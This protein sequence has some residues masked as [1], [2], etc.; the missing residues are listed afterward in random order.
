MLSPRSIDLFN[1]VNKVVT[2]EFN[3]TVAD[4]CSKIR[5]PQ[6]VDAKFVAW[7]LLHTKYRRAFVIIAD[8]YQ[9]DHT[10]VINGV[11]RVQRDP[12]ERM[13]RVARKLIE[14]KLNDND[15]RF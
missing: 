3:V 15:Q 2:E 13:I 14:T 1:M 11:R 12:S 7:Y 10:T 5:T 8:M 4:L 9:K 6:V